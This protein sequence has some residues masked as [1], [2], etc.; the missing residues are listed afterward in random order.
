MQKLGP[1]I[2]ILRRNNLAHSDSNVSLDQQV[3]GRV[4]SVALAHRRMS[5]LGGTDDSITVAKR[6]QR[7]KEEG[8]PAGAARG[9]SDSCG[10]SADGGCNAAAESSGVLPDRPSTGGSS[11]GA[12]S[13]TRTGAR[14]TTRS[15]LPAL[16]VLNIS[17]TLFA[18]VRCNVVLMA[19]PQHHCQRPSRPTRTVLRSRGREW[20]AS[21][22]LN[23]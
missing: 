8:E 21:C 2:V 4:D 23:R 15:M 5:R 13:P 9:G 7:R 18:A 3:V 1:P 14:C 11:E 16:A 6:R 17:L 10:R 20:L 22:S 19:T 12:A